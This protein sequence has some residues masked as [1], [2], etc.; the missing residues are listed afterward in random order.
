MTCDSKINFFN[1]L[2]PH[3]TEFQRLLT[4]RLNVTIMIIACFT[5]FTFS[6]YKSLVF[7]NHEP[8]NRYLRLQIIMIMYYT[9]H[10]SFACCC[11]CYVD[12]F[13]IIQWKRKWKENRKKISQCD[14]P[15]LQWK[16][17]INKHTCTWLNFPSCYRHSHIIVSYWVKRYVFVFFSSFF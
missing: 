16:P 14:S 7:W 12:M 1:L 13:S 9:F 4:N 17:H 2:L 10:M 5:C 11:V 8:N 6:W 15:K 3:W